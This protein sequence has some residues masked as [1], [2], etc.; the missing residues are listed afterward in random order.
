MARYDDR[1]RIGA[2]GSADRPA[3][4]GPTN[5]QGYIAIRTSVGVVNVLQGFPDAL[6][7]LSAY[8]RNPD[9]ELAP[10]A[11][12]VLVKFLAYLVKLSCVYGPVFRS[13]K[14]TA[15][16]RENDVT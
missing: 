9:G 6:L 15:A 11:C 8:G 2:I 10:C 3:S 1:N 7:E 16:R 4:R 13:F 12:K 14:G 5:L